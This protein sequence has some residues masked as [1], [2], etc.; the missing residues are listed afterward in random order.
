MERQNRK[1]Y[2]FD[3]IATLHFPPIIE[4]D[5]T[6]NG[7]HQNAQKVTAESVQS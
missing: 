1:K 2:R 5:D 3:M 7:Y 4:R 6:K